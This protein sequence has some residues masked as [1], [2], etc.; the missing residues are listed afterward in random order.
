MS[1][2]PAE[3]YR[4]FPWTVYPKP[5]FFR[6]RYVDLHPR[7]RRIIDSLPE[8]VKN[9]E[10]L[11]KLD[12]VNEQLKESIRIDVISDADLTHKQYILDETVLQDKA[13]I[14]VPSS[15]EIC[16]CYIHCAK[17]DDAFAMHT[18]EVLRSLINVTGRKSA[19]TAFLAFDFNCPVSAED[20]DRVTS[21]VFQKLGLHA[22]SD[23]GKLKFVFVENEESLPLAIS[24]YLEN[25][26]G[27]LKETEQKMG[28]VARVVRIAKELAFEIE[29]FLEQAIGNDFRPHAEPPIV[30]FEMRMEILRLNYVYSVGTVYNDFVIY[31][32]GQGFEPTTTEELE[33]DRFSTLKMSAEYDIKAVMK[34][35]CTFF[36]YKIQ[37]FSMPI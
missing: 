34:K 17:L 6:A 5:G 18:D 4:L 37:V 13:D 11:N 21:Y 9:Q 33:E 7:F 25:L 31:L 3:S 27:L 10:L 24:E 26:E 22:E 32:N 23:R 16:V 15:L 2:F 36:P 14:L 35:H 8:S 30:F 12:G 1:A 28:S 29:G 19:D 20:I